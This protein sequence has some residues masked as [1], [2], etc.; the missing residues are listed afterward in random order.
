VSEVPVAVVAEGE[1]VSDAVAG[2]D[3][4]VDRVEPAAVTSDDLDA[5]RVVFAVG[6]PSLL[7]VAQHA[8]ETPIAPVAAGFGRYDIPE[9]AVDAVVDAAGRD[10]L[11]T[12]AHPLVDV[13]VAGE[14]AG[15]AVAD[16]TLL[17]AA[18]ARISEFGIGSTDGW[19]ETIRADGV[20]VATPLGSTGYARDAG[21]PVIAPETGLVTVPISAYA[22][23][24]HPW[25]LRPP[26]SLSVERDEADVT[27][28]LDDEVVRSIP[29]ETT[30]D[31][32]TGEPL[33]LVD[34]QQ[35]STD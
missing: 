15:T 17:T 20:V 4:R 12:V 14:R 24:V 25:V 6:E 18:P 5:A 19:K 30:V 32:A 2:T 33:S 11:P 31:I 23:H 22:I 7:A 8:P 21:G 27:L 16:V 13:A 34:P 10:D 28:R 26:M 35:F 9:S 1:A 29:P 3:A